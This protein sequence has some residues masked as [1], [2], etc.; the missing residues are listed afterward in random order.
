MQVREQK[1]L[2]IATHT[3]ITPQDHLY[4]VPSQQSSRQYT[5]DVN[6][7]TCTCPDYETHRQKCK[8]I[9]A[10]E[11][12]RLHE[13]GYQLPEVERVRKPTYKQE[14]SAYNLAQT[15]EKAKFLELMYDL[16]N[17]IEDLPRKAGAGRNRLPMREMI[18]CAAFKTY[19]LFSGRRFTS[20]LRE[21]QRRGY[22]SHTPHFNSVFNYLELPEMTAYLKQLIIESSLPLKAIESDFAIDSSG[23]TTGRFSRWM[24]AKYTDPTMM[25]TLDWCKV[26]LMCGVKTNIVTAVEVSDRY[27]GDSPYFQPLVETTSRNFTMDEISADKAYS[28]EKNLKL[29]LVK[30]AQPYIPFKSSTT[31]TDKRS[32]ET[33]KRLYRYYLY[34]QDWFMQHYHKRSNV[35]TTFSMIKSKFGERIRSQEK[36]SQINEVLCKVLCHNLCCV[37]QSMYELGIE[38]EFEAQ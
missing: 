36:T 33:W 23:F 1:G 38:P 5:V 15:N 21:A 24:Q 9:Y 13:E 16:C 11:Y 35:E 17:G 7:Q 27:A 29:V 28:S 22:I 3:N 4:I 20:D 34:N 26:H 14:W 6:A 32:G 8:H 18:F 37:I 2:A 12:S 30:G 19:S 10:V 31:A 25:E